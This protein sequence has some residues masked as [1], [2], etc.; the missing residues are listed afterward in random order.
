MPTK[1]EDLTLVSLLSAHPA[2]VLPYFRLPFFN[3]LFP[4]R[5]I[6]AKWVFDYW[7]QNKQLPKLALLKKHYPAVVTLQTSEPL[8]YC[9]GILKQQY[10][11]AVAAGAGEKMTDALDKRDMTEFLKHN[12]KL[13]DLIS[14]VEKPLGATADDTD[15]YVEQLGLS[16]D[17]DS[18]IAMKVMPT[19]F[20]PLDDEDGGGLRPGH[21]YVLASLVNLGKTYVSLQVAENLR[22]AGYRVIY[23][24]TEMPK[25]DLMARAL[26]IRYGMDVNQ[27]IK[28]EQPQSSIAKGETKQDWFKGLLLSVQSKI[29]V[30][31]SKGKLFIRGCD[32]GALT[33]RQIAADIK[34]LSADVVMID[35]AQDIRDNAMTKERTPALYN[36]VSELNTLIKALNVA[37]FVTVQLDPDVEK[38]GLTQGN[39]NRI[40]WA[41]VFAQKAHV[42]MTML[43][44]RDS[45]FR[46]MCIE[47]TRDGK[48]GRK[49]WLT[50]KFPEVSITATTK[51]PGNLADLDPAQPVETVSELEKALSGMGASTDQRSMPPTASKSAI[52][53]RTPPKRADP[54]ETPADPSDEQEEAVSPY[55]RKQADKAKA[56]KPPWKKHHGK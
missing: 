17:K 6:A 44:S 27:L 55:A 7:E 53:T 1:D 2:D 49:F 36:A 19:K 14:T 51:T 12:G 39:L 26:A 45:D 32:E 11:D 16:L 46:D 31:T 50:F 3:D 5:K 56:K 9:F 40:Q 18:T 47:K 24:S 33:P 42:A 28:R 25:D 35:A 30:D 21:I 23:T 22:A 38:K 20:G 29:D 10:I 15:N 43:G 41:Q 34:E 13:H 48:A 54:V 52:P 8:P 4:T 37:L